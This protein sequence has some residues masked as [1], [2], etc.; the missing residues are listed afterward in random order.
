MDT[1]GFSQ[2]NDLVGWTEMSS[3]WQF[4][5]RGHLELHSQGF[6]ILETHSTLRAVF[7][8]VY[9]FLLQIEWTCS[10]TPG[11]AL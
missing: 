11:P 7:K 5:M 9:N 6:F 4:Q 1:A 10:T 8:K 3:Y 2:L